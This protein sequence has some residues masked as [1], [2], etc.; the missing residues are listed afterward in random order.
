MFE[1]KLEN[2]NGNI[3]D[4]NDGV[5]YVVLSVSG[6]NPPSA[7][8]FTSKSPNRKGARYNG[9]TLNERNIIV[10]IKILGDVESNRNALYAWI[11]T[12]QYAKIYYRNGVK[13]V[14]CEGH[15]EECEI[16]YFSDNEVIDLAIICE[17][18]YWKDL[19]A[20][21][22]EL[23]ALLKQFVFPFAIDSAGIPF[24]TVL[25]DVFPSVFYDGAETGI[26]MSVVFSEETKNFSIFDPHDIKRVFKFKN[27]FPKESM[28]EIDTDS[29]PKTC[30]LIKSDGSTENAL[31]YIAGSPTWFTLKKG[32]NYFDYDSDHGKSGIE[33]T[34]GF[35]NRYL[36]V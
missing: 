12:E 14:Y 7:S 15:V 25:T 29:S 36:G 16:D 31:K 13:N 18:P 24:S 4:I 30:R 22:A 9:S 19:Q 32:Y 5:K 35:V 34:V 1:F 10:T 3:V 6:L 28:L 26:K 11:D 20:I 33:I 23:T 8:I 27:T 2:S 17:D 21:S